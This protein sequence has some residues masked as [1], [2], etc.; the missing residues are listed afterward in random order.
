MGEVRVRVKSWSGNGAVFEFPLTSI[1]SPDGERRFFFL[2]LVEGVGFVY[3]E[4]RRR[5]YSERSRGKPF[6]SFHSFMVHPE[7]F[8]LKGKPP[9]LIS[10]F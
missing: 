5:V 10:P 7:G 1:L 4:R 6:D 8:S 3:P 9:Q 2:G